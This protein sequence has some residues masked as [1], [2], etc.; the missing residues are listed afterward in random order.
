VVGLPRAAHPGSTVR[1]PKA[2]SRNQAAVVKQQQIGPR[3]RDNPDITLGDVRGAARTGQL[4]GGVPIP[5]A[6]AGKAKK[7]L[8]DKRFKK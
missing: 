3:I 4:P 1:T 6:V 8:T 2:A 5:K 7:I